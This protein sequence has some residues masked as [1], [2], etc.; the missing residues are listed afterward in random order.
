[1]PTFGDYET[2]GDPIAVG[3]D[4]GHISTVW[5]A[6]KPGASDGREYV[7]KRYASHLR[8]TG[9]AAETQTLSRDRGLEFLEGIKA[10]KKA[11]SAG[12][13]S[14]API[15]DFGLADTGVWYV[16][17][18]YPRDNLKA[19]IARKGRVDSAGVRHV[20]AQLVTGCLALKRS[21]GYSH[22]N[23][24]A[25]N[26]FRAGKKGTF[27]QTP[28]LLTDPY[29]A[30]AV[31][32]LDA[33]NLELLGRTMEAED[34][35][36]IGEILLQLVE[37]RLLL[38]NEDYNWPIALSPAW[39]N[40]G[41]DAERWLQLCNQ[42]LNPNRS[43]EA[44]SLETLAQQYRPSAGSGKLLLMVAAVIVVVGVVGG[45]IYVI[46][47]RSDGNRT[48]EYQQK[49]LEANQ[50]YRLI[51]LI[52]AL[53]KVDAA[54]AVNP[55]GKEAAELRPKIEAAIERDFDSAIK[56]G[57]EELKTG[58]PESLRA[59]DRFL[60]S[61]KTLKPQ[62]ARTGELQGLITAANK[63]IEDG[64]R[65]D[66]WTKALADY[67]QKA[68]AEAKAGTNWLQASNCYAL[69]VTNAA[70]LTND[71]DRRRAEEG[72]ANAVSK[73]QK[74]TA[75]EKIQNE[76]QGTLDQAEKAT[77]PDGVKRLEAALEKAKM[78]SDP[79][80]KQ[81]VEN[82]LK[83]AKLRL[84]EWQNN[85]TARKFIGELIHK[86]DVAVNA[87][88]W[89]SAA[90]FFDQALTNAVGIRDTDLQTSAR[91][92]LRS[93]K[94][95]LDEQQAQ[96][97][98]AENK[99]KENRAYNDALNALK[100]GSFSDA[101]KSARS[102]NTPRF[103]E[104]TSQIDREETLWKTVTTQLAQSQY[105]SIINATNLPDAKLFDDLR[106]AAKQE[107]NT[108]ESA[109]AEFK[110]GTTNGVFRFLSSSPF[111]NLTN[112]P[113]F[114]KLAAEARKELVQAQTAST[115]LSPTNL[116]AARRY[117]ESV[118]LQGKMNK[119]PFKT[120]GEQLAALE[121]GVKAAEQNFKSLVAA[122][123]KL[124][125][126]RKFADAK[127]KANEALTNYPGVLDQTPA[128]KLINQA[129]TRLDFNAATLAFK[130]CRH[131]EAL[132]LCTKHA[133]DGDISKLA[134]EIK[135][136]VTNYV[137]F[138]NQLSSG[139]YTFVNQVTEPLQSKSCVSN[140]LSQASFESA[141][142]VS[143]QLLTNNLAN[144]PDVKA[145]MD[146]ASVALKAKSPFLEINQWLIRNDPVE[147]LKLEIDLFKIW[148]GVIDPRPDV[149]DPYTGQAAI[150]APKGA[151]PAARYT[152]L[153]QLKGQAKQYASQLG[154]D[155]AKE[156]K[157][158]EKAMNLMDQ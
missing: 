101:R 72:L 146:K 107:K 64:T 24:K 124:L 66:E 150:K 54:L 38:S 128:T 143:L 31:V 74:R 148:Y 71:E 13:R 123:E 130:D 105:D 86:G 39:R 114:S 22:G 78:L 125:G 94:Q 27:H 11:Q 77:P 92:K 6:V 140:L 3:E 93:A 9:N 32:E 7:V 12:G 154:G 108:F 73:L 40:L 23:V 119:E 20:V 16:T 34:L 142:L 45:G 2:V 43:P 110:N 144:W 26:A 111:Y 136:E 69:A 48:K 106:A 52:E 88:N 129:E 42:L 96:Q 121:A 79:Q 117:L 149:L 97:F 55:T 82:A 137:A 5:R 113:G 157:D 132:E 151:P 21:R 37:G 116:V 112:K 89:L 76:I 75:D 103:A 118:D 29:P 57:N 155:R 46:K 95:K 80:I 115:L 50:A 67:L 84:G 141:F 63:K 83:L 91:E 138:S 122:G 53:A 44:L 126:E 134:K 4:R 104:L 90:N 120:M 131:D 102:F 36:A 59:A 152:R 14:L 145:R 153:D 109:N 33:R 10:Q 62:D 47:N 1:M 30:G 51:N 17:D 8:T 99:Q 15:H 58:T 28:I 133:E 65:R 25:G 18:F 81:R 49:V 158:I 156:F 60:K 98:T 19:W 139:D 35:R 87:M 135:S 56:S 61:A 147:G 100:A 70:I 85:E 68:D 41:K 127:T